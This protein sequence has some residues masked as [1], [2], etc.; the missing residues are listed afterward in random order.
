MRVG[1]SVYS[2]CG[3]EVAAT[4]RWSNYLLDYLPAIDTCLAEFRGEE[5]YVS[6]AYTMPGGET[7]IRV[8]DSDVRTWECATR[9]QGTAINSIRPLDAADAVFGEGDPI[10][11]RG[12][13]PAF[14]E[15]CYVYEAVREA[16]GSLIGAFGHD[17]CDV[18]GVA[19]REPD[20]GVG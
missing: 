18:G 19:A 2:G 13:M 12:I 4:D 16:D 1:E 14:G 9:E 10:F 8:V 11:V 20:A 6:V 17:S 7:A 3:S 15:G 5:A